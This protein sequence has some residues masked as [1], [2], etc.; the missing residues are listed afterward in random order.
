MSFPNLISVFKR[1]PKELF[2]VNNGRIV[3]V[4]SRRPGR[5]VYDI[6]VDNGLVKPKAL[7]PS[8]YAG[9]W[10]LQDVC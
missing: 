5:Q 4:R 1:F 2:R 10:H 8:T 9:Q 6:I 7:S 3:T